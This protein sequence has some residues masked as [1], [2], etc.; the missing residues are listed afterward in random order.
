M[1]T[2]KGP[3]SRCDLCWGWGH[4]ENKCGRKP[5]CGFCSGHHWRSDHKCN[6]VG[7]TA[8]QGS[9]CGHTLEKR[10]N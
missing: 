6:E 7:S 5:K 8:K 10:P 1:I 9:L 2:N 4:M 3:D